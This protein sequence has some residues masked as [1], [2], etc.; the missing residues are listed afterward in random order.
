LKAAGLTISLD[1]NDDPADT[2]GGVL[3][4]LLDK[5]DLLLPNEDE[6]MRITRKGSLEVALDALAERVPLI[7]VKCGSRGAVV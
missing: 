3:D 2:W 6:V 1:T 5:I 7:V 4:L